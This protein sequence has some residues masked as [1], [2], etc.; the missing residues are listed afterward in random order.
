MLLI[1]LHNISTASSLLKSG[2]QLARNLKQE[3]GVLAFVERA[4]EVNAKKENL[5]KY[6][7]DNEFNDF[8]V[9]VRPK[10]VKHLAEEC[11]AVEASFLMMQWSHSQKKQLKNRLKSCRDLRIPYVFFKE[12]FPQINFEKVMVPVGFLVEE[13]EKA[14]FASAFG[15]FCGSEIT[16]LLAND[17]GTKAAVTAEKMK[18]L[19]GKFNLNFNQEKAQSDS[20]K[21]DKEAVKVAREKNYGIVIISA[22]RDYGLDDLLFGPKEYHLIHRSDV[23]LLLV[24]PRGDLY[25]LC[26]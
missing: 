21:L 17:Y 13:Y 9:F 22:S 1:L 5:A 6:L 23:P 10:S 14:Q 20:F 15:R 8:R 12:E 2:Y 7:S 24:N 11:E 18:E 26:D 4:E 3:V 25:T 16:I 19:F